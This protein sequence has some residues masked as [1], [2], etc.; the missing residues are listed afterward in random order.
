[1]PEATPGIQGIVDELLRSEL[2]REAGRLTRN[3]A[4]ADDL[5]QDTV[6]RGLRKKELYRYGS[7]RT[8]LLHIMKNLFIDRCRRRRHVDTGVELLS[9]PAESTPVPMWAQVSDVALAA[10]IA[11][12]QPLAREVIVLKEREGCSYAEISERLNIPV[13]T[14][15]TRLIRARRKLREILTGTKSVMPDGEKT[16]DRDVQVQ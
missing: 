10:A 8:W 3:A 16:E 12:L 7:L 15:G 5:V 2:R 11:R 1:M 14:V 9:I 4:D 13:G 6:E